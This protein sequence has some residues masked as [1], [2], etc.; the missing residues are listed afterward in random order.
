MSNLDNQSWKTLSLSLKDRIILR[1]QYE[2]LKEIKKLRGTL[3]DEECK[4]YD[5]TIEVLEMGYEGSYLS[6]LGEYHEALTKDECFFVNKILA[7]YNRLKQPFPGF[8]DK[9]KELYYLLY[10]E[11]QVK[12]RNFP[13]IKEQ[14][15]KDKSLGSKDG[16]HLTE[17][18]EILESERSK[19]YSTMP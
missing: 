17:Y 15:E 13:Y 18:E 7:H 16:S 1:N 5:R 19:I 2:I 11:F 4:K 3:E 10:A 12:N 6:H 14:L 8:D 9:G